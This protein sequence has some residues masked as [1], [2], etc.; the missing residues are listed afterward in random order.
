VN[1][2]CHEC[3]LEACALKIKIRSDV[4]C[5]VCI[6][7]PPAG[8]L[9]NFLKLFE[10]MLAHLHT[11]SINLIICGDVNI[12][13]LQ[14]SSSKNQLDSLLAL[15][16]LYGVV[17]FPTR[18]TE[19]SST[20]IDNFFMD[21]GKNSKYSIRPI[22]NGL[23]DHDAQLLVL[24]DAIINKQIPHSTI[25]RQINEITIAQFK[26]NLS[27][28]NW[29]ETF[30]EDNIDINFKNF[31]NTYLRIFNSTF[32]YKRIYPNRNGNAWIT[33]GI[34]ISCKRKEALYILSK[35]TQN[36][37]LKN[38][39][40]T[41]SKI[42]SGVIRAAKKMHFNNLLSR[43]HNKVKTM[44]N[45]VK[46]EINKQNRSDVPP[47]NIEGSPANDYQELACVFNEY[48][49]NVINPTQTD[50][51]KEDS[52]VA[53]NLNTVCNRPFGQIDLTPVTAQ[54]IKIIRSLKWTTASGYDGVS[55]RLLKLS[56]PYIISPLTYL[57]NKSLT[58]GIFP[59]WLKYSQVTPI[60]KKGN[61]CELSNYRPI[62]L[63]TSFSKIFEKV[64][65]KRLANHTSAH[66]ILSKAQ[67]GFRTNMSTEN[68]IY[69]LMN[70][71]LKA[72]DNKQ[73]VGG[74]FCDLSKA[75]DCVDHE[76]LLSKLEYY[77]VRGTANKLIKSYLVD[78]SQRVLIKDSYSGTHYSEWRKVREVFPK[79]RY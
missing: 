62:S 42:L 51:L 63:L 15:Y 56:L 45:F 48:F 35:N 17:D 60:F 44:W 36:P 72:L 37:K 77:G 29:S 73:H 23:S 41:Y 74:M 14:T 53:E 55:P 57:C 12:N 69:Q 9:S 40:T 11:P 6:Y 49:I 20:A 70:N 28:E 71:I 1:R 78:R 34:K 19:S 2:Y 31:L 52:S 13:Y 61:K 43:S 4:H 65:Y 26:L 50:N 54:E 68:A 46:T 59:T 66:N 10:S 25:I 39:Y 38:H 33:K 27:Y 3:D 67:Y 8:D 47:L 16:N 76:T 32:S 30:T 22:Y 79:V 18:I 75:F 24:H 58:S 7:R 21:K 64:I 5:I